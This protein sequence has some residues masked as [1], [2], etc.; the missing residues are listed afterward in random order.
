MQSSIDMLQDQINSLAAVILQNHRSL[1]SPTWR[2]LSFP[3][4]RMLYYAN[5]SGIVRK[6]SCQ[7]WECLKQRDH[8]SWEALS[9]EDL[10]TS[11]FMDRSFTRIFNSPPDGPLLGPCVTNTLTHFLTEHFETIQHQPL[12]KVTSLS[13]P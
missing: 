8:V 2:Y 13:A 5:K 4:R 10:W 9:D 1:D 6:N 11:S 7:L 3:A 12:L